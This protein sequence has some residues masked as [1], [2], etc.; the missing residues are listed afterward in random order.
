VDI[1]CMSRILADNIQANDGIKAD[2][3]F[4][5]GWAMDGGD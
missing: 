2:G 3:A 4:V 1:V 5:A